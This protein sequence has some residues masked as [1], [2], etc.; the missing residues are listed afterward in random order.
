MLLYERSDC[1]KDKVLREI[2]ISRSPY[3]DS[4]ALDNI[5]NYIHEQLKFNEDYINGNII[6]SNDVD[7]VRIYYLVG[8]TDIPIIIV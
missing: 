5:A 3:D 7:G 4:K 6:L 2:Y 1:M 8:C